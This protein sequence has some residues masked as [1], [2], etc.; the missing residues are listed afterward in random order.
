MIVRRNP[1]VLE[2]L[3]LIHE[4]SCRRNG[5]SPS[6]IVVD[7]SRYSS[8]LLYPSDLIHHSDGTTSFAGIRVD[9]SSSD[10]EIKVL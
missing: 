10:D 7:N 2:L 6:R 4:Y 3:N 9:I 8:L 1:E 5:V